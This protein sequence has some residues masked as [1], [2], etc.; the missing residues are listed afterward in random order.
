MAKKTYDAYLL[1][2]STSFLLIGWSQFVIAEP[3]GMT[4]PQEYELVTDEDVC[5][6]MAA[7]ALGRPFDSADCHSSFVGCLVAGTIY[8]SNCDT[9]PS[10]PEVAPVCQRSLGQDQDQGTPIVNYSIRMALDNSSMIALTG[11]YVIQ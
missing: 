1:H 8:F 6:D 3:G 4:C 5:R 10:G 2:S 7:P 11:A 9:Q